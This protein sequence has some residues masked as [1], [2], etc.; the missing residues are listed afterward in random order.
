LDGIIFKSKISSAYRNNWILIL[1]SPICII[2]ILV[3]LLTPELDIILRIFI[4]G[5]VLI[6]FTLL[7]WLSLQFIVTYLIIY[8]NGI[9]FIKPYRFLRQIFITWDSIED[10]KLTSG[11]IMSSSFFGKYRRALKLEI[12]LK[13]QLKPLSITEHWVANIESAYEII[14]NKI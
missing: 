7:I 2:P 9:K 14:K 6:P 3:A 13:N 11:G 1:F 12:F 8:E 5:M 4:V 10:V